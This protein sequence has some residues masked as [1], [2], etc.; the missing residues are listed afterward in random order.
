M[1]SPVYN[2]LLSRINPLAHYFPTLDNSGLLE[3]I[4]DD[5]LFHLEVSLGVFYLRL[6]PRP[7]SVI[8]QLA[9]LRSSLVADIKSD[10]A[11]QLHLVDWDKKHEEV[12]ISRDDLFDSIYS[13]Q[14]TSELNCTTNSL[15]R[16][17]IA[18]VSARQPRAPHIVIS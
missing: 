17:L 12:D 5:V 1:L 14:Q 4:E 10:E 16:S 11:G 6:P 3:W 7:S 13:M 2:I 8:Y 18:K 15:L 9:D